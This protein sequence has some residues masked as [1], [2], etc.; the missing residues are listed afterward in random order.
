MLT[1]RPDIDLWDHVGHCV[2][3][4]TV[5]WVRLV[6]VWVQVSS[7]IQDYVRVVVQHCLAVLKLHVQVAGREG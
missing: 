5:V 1:P 7:F 4:S 3:G 6:L 2:G